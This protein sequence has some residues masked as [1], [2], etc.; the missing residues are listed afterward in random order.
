MPFFPGR[1]HSLRLGIALAVVSG[2]VSLAADDKKKPLVFGTDVALVQ[3]PVFVSGRGGGAVSGLTASDFSVQQDG[4]DVEVV[5]FRYVDTS[6]PELQEEIRQTS[7]ARCS[8]SWRRERCAAIS[9][10]FIGVALPL[11]TTRSM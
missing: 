9:K 1:S 4:K 8:L 5:S 2:A 10:I 7:A 3:V 11:N 6:A